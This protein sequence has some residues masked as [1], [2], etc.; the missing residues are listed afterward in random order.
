MS[1]RSTVYLRIHASDQDVM[2]RAAEPFAGL[3]DELED[4]EDGSVELTYT[5]CRVVDPEQWAQAGVPFYGGFS[6]GS[7]NGYGACL[8]AYDG[9]TTMVHSCDHDGDPVT[10]IPLWEPHAE[11]ELEAHSVVALQ[12]YRRAYVA[13]RGGL[14]RVAEGLELADYHD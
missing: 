8:F 6:A 7:D 9:T 3:Y 14:P 13:V 12:I 4:C 11:P 2:E 1:D 10:K 5:H